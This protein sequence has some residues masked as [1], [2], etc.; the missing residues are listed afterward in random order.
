M[1]RKGEWVE[2]ASPEL[3]E[4]LHEGQSIVIYVSTSP[5][6]IPLHAR[7]AFDDTKNSISIEY[8]YINEEPTKIFRIDN[9]SFA[10]IG[11]NS[12]RIYSLEI[13]LS[14]SN[15]G[16]LSLQLF[17]DKAIDQLKKI[18]KTEAPRKRN[19]TLAKNVIDNYWSPLFN[20]LK[21][22]NPSKEHASLTH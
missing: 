7:G 16:D 22:D 14:K 3:V 21:G 4:E 19:Y 9:E 15:I 1:E 5:Y 8:R 10:L 17:A 11:K 6:D 18:V 13:H 2:V 20:F 12:G